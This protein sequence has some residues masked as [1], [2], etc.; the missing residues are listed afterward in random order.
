MVLQELLEQSC[1]PT[2]DRPVF[3]ETAGELMRRQP[4]GDFMVEFI[5]A[6]LFRTIDYWLRDHPEMS[7]EEY[8]G[9]QVQMLSKLGKL[10]SE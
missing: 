3:L 10:F 9:L 1:E 6:G 7:P 5:K 2:P 4:Y 8:Y